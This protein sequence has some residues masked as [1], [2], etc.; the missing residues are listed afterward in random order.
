MGSRPF[1]P[2]V[3]MQMRNLFRG[4]ASLRFICF[5]GIALQT[6]LANAAVAHH[7]YD[8]VA[9]PRAVVTGRL[10]A[11]HGSDAAAHPHGVGD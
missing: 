2:R 4:I 8:P 7:S 5:L 1:D 9:D 6:A 11:I 10:C 3:P